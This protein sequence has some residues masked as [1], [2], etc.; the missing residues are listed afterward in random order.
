MILRYIS[1]VLILFGVV[2]N[3][4]INFRTVI[5]LHTGV[6]TQTYTANT[7]GTINTIKT[8]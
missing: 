1:L 5:C 7:F 2:I 6:S 4:S 8:Q 3:R